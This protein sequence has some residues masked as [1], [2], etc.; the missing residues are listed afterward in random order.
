MNLA[1]KREL[2]ARTLGVGKARILFNTQR[3]AEIKEA[4]TK[5]DIRDL[6]ASGAIMINDI[7]GR[8]AVVRRVSRRKAG[9]IKK[10]HNP[11]KQ[12]Y[13]KLVRRL[14]SYLF[15]LRKHEKISPDLYQ[16]MRKEI[17]ASAFKTKPSM[18]ERIAQEA[19]K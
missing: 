18:K 7:H 17:R 11:K 16:K 5:Q 10:K 14:R 6:V 9:K 3:L 4:I 2:A 15:E 13:V 1:K 19:K 12:G 8:R